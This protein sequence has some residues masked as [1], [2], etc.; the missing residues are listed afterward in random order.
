MQYSCDISVK[1][2][3]VNYIKLLLFSPATAEPGRDILYD[4]EYAQP[5]QPEQQG[6]PRAFMDQSVDKTTQSDKKEDDKRQ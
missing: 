6:R 5:N 1:A 3:I 2:S 4:I